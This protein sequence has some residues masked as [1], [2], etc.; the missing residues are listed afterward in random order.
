MMLM[1]WLDAT[2]LTSMGIATGTKVITTNAAVPD[3]IEP[4]ESEVF[5]VANG[6]SL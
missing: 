2:K 5:V 1:E 3:D 4:G 6:G